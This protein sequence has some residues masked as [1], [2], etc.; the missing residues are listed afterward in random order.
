MV[1]LS[2]INGF[3]NGTRNGF[4]QNQLESIGAVELMVE[5]Q[6]LTGNNTTILKRNKAS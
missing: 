4:K 3:R 2:G 6:Q 1:T 5:L